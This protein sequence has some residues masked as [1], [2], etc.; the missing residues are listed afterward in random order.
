[1]KIVTAC[2]GM[3][4]LALVFAGCIA[5]SDEDDGRTDSAA[6]AQLDPGWKS[7]TI[8]Q[9]GSQVASAWAGA[10]TGGVKVEYWAATS[11]Y[12][13]SSARDLTGASQTCAAW[14]RNVCGSSSK[15]MSY[16]HAVY[17]ETTLDCALPPGP[18]TP[19][20]GAVSFLGD[21]SYRTADG[22]GTPFAWTY[23]SGSCEYWAMDHTISTG[24]SSQGADASSWS[25]LSDF[26]KA[27]CTKSSVPSTWYTVYY[28][29]ITCS[30]ITC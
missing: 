27:M 20:K 14:K 11:D 21:G 17:T 19:S 18:C 6:Q 30:D 26:E 3:A 8:T 22:A 23:V 25:S 24:T 2:L 12:A 5:P 13:A 16:Y 15:G 28:E 29:P 10:I 1:M 9:A 4:G 7:Y